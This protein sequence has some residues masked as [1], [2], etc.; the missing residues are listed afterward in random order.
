M[1]SR[2]PSLM[3]T[4]ALDA[5]QPPAAP[6]GLCRH[7]WGQTW[8]PK[9]FFGLRLLGGAQQAMASSLAA[10]MP[11]VSGCGSK[12]LEWLCSHCPQAPWSPGSACRTRNF[13]PIS[14]RPKVRLY[15][16]IPPHPPGKHSS[17]QDSS[18][19]SQSLSLLAQDTCRLDTYWL[20]QR[21]RGQDGKHHLHSYLDFVPEPQLRLPE[22][23][24][25]P[26]VLSF[27]PQN[28]LVIFQD[29]LHNSQP[30]VGHT[31]LTLQRAP[32]P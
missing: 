12:D 3:I 26:H 18:Q 10:T 1:G 25:S 29:P 19:D 23:C 9:S 2:H 8:F 27:T 13:T 7:S 21:G 22:R 14:Q 4:L 28:E 17:T 11:S 6:E 15:K 16:V 20:D 32:E 24:S 31:L 5:S 30:G